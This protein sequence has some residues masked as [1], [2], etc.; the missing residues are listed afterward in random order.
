VAQ[1]FVNKQIVEGVGGGVCQVSTTLYNAALRARLPIVERHQHSLPVPYIS[2][3]RDATVAYPYRDLKFKNPT[4]SL[5]YIQAY[6]YGSRLTVVIWGH[7]ESQTAARLTSRGR[8]A[9]MAF[10]LTR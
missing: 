9:I 6:P 8:R 4:N 10:A 3:G 5:I 2:R 7:R 1:I